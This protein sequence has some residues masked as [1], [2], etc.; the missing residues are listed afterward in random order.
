[1]TR[2]SS[3][4]QAVPLTHTEIRL[5]VIGILLAM[6]LAALDQ[7]IVV[8]AMPTI[9]RELGDVASLP[10]VVTAYL[11][12]STAVTP[13]YGKV[14]DIIG[15][16]TTLLFAIV[17][18]TLGSIACALSPSM[19]V[20]IVARAL[21]G[22]GGG[23]LISLAQTIIA[24][25]V[26]PKE[27]PRYQ[28]YVA[29]VFVTSSVAGPLFGGVLAEHA[30]WSMI[31]WLN[32]PLGIVAF[33]MTNGLLKKLP[34]HERPHSLDFLGAG[35]MV[36]ATVSLM[37]ALNWGGHQ[38]A[39]NSPQIEALLA[40]SVLSWILFVWRLRTAPEPF[41]PTEV[42][43]NDV[44][45]FGILTATMGMGT[46]IGMTAYLPIYMETAYGL[47]SSQS[48]LGLI[49]F[50]VG[51]VTGA[52]L[53]SR[54]MATITSYK[55][56]PMVG[57]GVAAAGLSAVALVPGGVPLWVLEILLPCVSVGLGSILPITTVAIQ[58]AVMPHQMGTA[59]GTMNFFRS[60]GGA[61]LVA[62]FGAILFV[63]LQEGNAVSAFR[64]VFAVAAAAMAL[65]FLFF[66]NMP[67]KPLRAK[68]AGAGE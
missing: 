39:W 25:I 17:V 9:G 50:M 46:F 38:Y 19:I 55:R 27:R 29:G 68:V 47:T 61:L 53:A 54:S 11:V 6:L 35:L 8:T 16:R 22:L 62:G 48:G 12:A 28:I 52:T 30:H 21:Q 65:S 37:L 59:T 2:P 51:T 45:K 10:W 66:W 44:V 33:L 56:W 49:P 4:S 42:L 63:Q 57:L 67:E 36:A 13:L 34:R 3:D 31:F 24:D 26:S 5:I 32:L 60:L 1:M 58:N 43:G 18:F 15:R 7:T 64:P 14:S 23:G 40:A 41:I 20:L